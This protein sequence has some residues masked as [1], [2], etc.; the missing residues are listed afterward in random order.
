MLSLTFASPDA[1]TAAARASIGAGLP[2]WTAVP[3][4]AVRTGLTPASVVGAGLNALLLT[5]ARAGLILFGL[6]RR[7]RNRPRTYR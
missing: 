4:S 6:T 7:L 1:P 3:M 2:L 5:R